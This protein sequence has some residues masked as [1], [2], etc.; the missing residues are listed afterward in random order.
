MKNLRP[1]SILFSKK[2]PKE[3]FKTN[4]T[5]MLVSK[6]LDFLKNFIFQ[7]EVKYDNQY[8]QLNAAIASAEDYTN[9]FEDVNSS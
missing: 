3:K 9:K 2:E 1:F 4:S 5:L 7:A 6:H 8:T